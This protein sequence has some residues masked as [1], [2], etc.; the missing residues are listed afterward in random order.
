MGVYNTKNK[1]LLKESVQSI[2]S[3]TYTDWELIICDDGSTDNTLDILYEIEKLDCRIKILSYKKNK[4]LS[5]ALNE[6]AKESKGEYIARQDDDDIS[7]P[8][9]LETLLEF[10]NEHPEYSIVGSCADVYDLNGIWGAY[11]VEENPTDKSFLWSNPFAHPTT[12]MRAEALKKIGYY[13]VAKETRRCEDYDLFMR[14]YANG[15]I[16]YNIQRRLYKYYILND[17]RKYRPMKYRIDEAIVRFHGYKKLN[18]YPI[19]F[20]FVIKPILIGLIPQSIFKTI[21]T[22]NYKV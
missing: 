7:Y 13:R 8:D 14:M 6:C 3:Q 19:G 12:M 10:F 21:R 5:Y 16:G 15:F 17:N 4:G 18:L 2:I 20:F 1:E 22:R 11:T 9:R